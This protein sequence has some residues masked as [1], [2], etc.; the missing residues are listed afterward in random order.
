MLRNPRHERFAREYAKLGI[1][2][3]AYLK[4]GYHP[5]TRNALDVSACQLLSKPKIAKRVTELQQMSLGKYLVTKESLT[6]DLVDD[7]EEARKAGNHSAV[8][9]STVALG[10]LHGQ[11]IDRKEVGE[12]G[13]F[14]GMETVADVLEKVRKEAGEDAAAAL[15]KVLGAIKPPAEDVDIGSPASDAIN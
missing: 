3:R 9:A 15:A 7:R 12:P 14:A 11:W 8:T 4:A 10:K 5:T 1:A 6:K 13:S 2:S